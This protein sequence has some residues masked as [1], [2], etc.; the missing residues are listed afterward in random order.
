MDF[1]SIREF[2]NQP[3]KVWEKLAKD[4]QLVVTR[5]GKPFAI[6]TETSSADLEADLQDLRRARFGRALAALRSEAEKKGLD[7]L[8]LDQINEIIHKARE[9]RRNESRC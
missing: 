6:L 3:G 1:I 9:A 2:R 7:K 4:H 8:S 5:N